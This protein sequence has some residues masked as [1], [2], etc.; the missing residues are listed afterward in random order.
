MTKIL[1]SNIG[2][3][4][5]YSVALDYLSKLGTVIT[6]N[7]KIRFNEE[8]F[9]ENI[10]NVEVIITGTEPISRKVIEKATKLKLIARVGVGLDN[11]DLEAAK[12]R[13]ISICYTPEAPSL[14]VPEFTL[15]LILNLLKGISFSD[16]QMNHGVWTRPMGRMLASSKIGILGAGKIGSK[17]IKLIKAIEPNCEIFYFDLCEGLDIQGVS[18]KDLEFIFEN[19]DIIS[20]HLPLNNN[21]FDFINGYLIKKMKKEAF[22]INTARG[23]IVNEKDLFL[24]LEQ[25][26]IAG[27]ALDVF[28]KE[29]YNGPLCGLK[30]CILTCHMGSLTYEVR[31]MME[32]QIVEDIERFFMGK[33]LLRPFIW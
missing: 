20:I 33:S 14:A 7:Q 27:A 13:K 5:A 32:M 30:N 23:G 8:K 12:K 9:L 21:T 19:S 22:L 31:F 4:E 10:D 17:V 24:A 6:N 3:G 11:V 25:N 15:G 1:I 2:F 18:K 29:P 16:K 26:K 28:E